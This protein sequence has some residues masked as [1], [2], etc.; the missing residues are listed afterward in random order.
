MG[1]FDYWKEKTYDE[2]KEKYNKELEVK[3][4]GLINLYMTVGL[5]DRPIGSSTMIICK[6]KLILEPK[7]FERKP[8]NIKNCRIVSR[9]DIKKV[10]I[11]SKEQIEHQ[12]KMG[13]MMLM[14]AYALASGD[15]TK[16]IYSQQIVLDL[17][18]EEIDFSISTGLLAE[19]MQMLEVAKKLNRWK[20][21][22]AWE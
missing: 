21:T 7:E 17:C 14:G 1:F 2:R 10:R 15:K 4:L 3:V 19:A 8:A 18:E 13:E 9:E 11:M 20:N 16:T 12:S 6:D 22:G 5:T